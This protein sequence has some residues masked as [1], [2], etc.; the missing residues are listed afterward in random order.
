LSSAS[1]NATLNAPWFKFA[2]TF[3]KTGDDAVKFVKKFY[4]SREEEMRSGGDDD[5]L[6]CVGNVTLRGLNFV[7]VAPGALHHFPEDRKRDY[8]FHH[9][10]CAHDH[11]P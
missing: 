6:V 11:H 2:T 3:L 1:D 8:M 4:G 5:V 7:E 10:G 9:E